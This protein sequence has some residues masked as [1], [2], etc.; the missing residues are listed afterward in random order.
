MHMADALISPAVGGAMAAVSAGALAMAARGV[1]REAR[2]SPEAHDRTALMGVLGAFVF[3]AQMINF[4]IPATGSSG[5]LGG[6]LLLAILLGPHAAFL[7]IAS[8]LIVQALFFADG[9]LLALGCNLFNM[10]FLACYVAYPLIFRPIAGRR[11]AGRRIWFGSML[12]AVVALQLGAACVV[13][14]TTLS[15]I[16]ELP[17]GGFIAL[18]LPIHLAIGLAEG[19]VTAAV[20][21]FIAQARPELLAPR[22]EAASGRRLRPVL[23]GLALVAALTA[24]VM[25]W[26]ASGD[27]DGLEWSLA[28]AAGVEE[29]AAPE[30]GVHA[31]L[32]RAQE[33]TALLPDYDFPGG[34]A[35]EIADE[36]AVVRAG[37]STAGLIGAMLTLGLAGA[38]GFGLRRRASVST[39]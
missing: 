20:V 12:G 5:H 17:F 24:G 26:F 6:G 9:G 23:V 1:R 8:V 35:A 39:P 25:S 27:P 37:V 36:A 16:S 22:A 32:A 7:T 21:G 13:M 34:E 11:A 28:R 19:L 14:Q 31:V 15:G 18:M 3:A 33:R 29:L 10:G 30:A 4:S 2:E 38:I